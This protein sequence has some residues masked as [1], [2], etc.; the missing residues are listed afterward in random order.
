MDMIKFLA[1][2]SSFVLMVCLVLAL[3]SLVSLRH[4]VAESSAVQAK[5]QLD[6]KFIRHPIGPVPLMVTISRRETIAETIT[7]TT[8]FI[9]SPLRVM[10]T[11][12]G[13]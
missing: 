10:M 11:S 6:R 4:A 8:G 5:A 2:I 3:T 12:F 7:G 9:V 13:S 1:V